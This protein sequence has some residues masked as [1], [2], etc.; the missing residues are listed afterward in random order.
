M[1]RVD[2]WSL[3]IYSFFVISHGLKWTR[4][5]VAIV[6]TLIDENQAGALIAICLAL[7]PNTKH[8]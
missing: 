3:E 6:V 7:L 8:V 4:S 1:I 5:D 2:I